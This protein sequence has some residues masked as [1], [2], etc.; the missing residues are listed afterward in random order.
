MTTPAPPSQPAAPVNHLRC[1]GHAIRTIFR[2][3]PALGRASD[4]VNAP[5]GLGV[6][7]FVVAGVICAVLLVGSIVGAVSVIL[8]LVTRH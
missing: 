7:H 1:V 3:L 5:P 4:H 8:N 2:V 6:R